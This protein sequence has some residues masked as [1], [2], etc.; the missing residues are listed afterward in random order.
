MAEDLGVSVQSAFCSPTVRR[1]RSLPCE[2]SRHQFEC[3]PLHGCARDLADALGRDLRR[4]RSPSGV[5]HV[6]HHVCLSL[7]RPSSEAHWS[8][9][10]CSYIATCLGLAFTQTYWLLMLLRCLQAAGSASVVALGAGAIGDLAP[11]KERGGYM[12]IYSLGA[13]LGPCI[14]PL[15]GGLLADR[16]DWHAIFFF[17]AAFSAVVFCVMLLALPEV[18][19]ALAAERALGLTLTSCH[20]DF[21]IDGRERLD[22]AYAPRE[23]FLG[24]GLPGTT[25]ANLPSTG[26]NA[27]ASPA[28][29][30]QPFRLARHA[31]GARRLPPPHL[32]R[33]RL[34]ALLREHYLVLAV[35]QSQVWPLR[36]RARTVLSCKRWRHDLR[37]GLQRSSAQP[38]L[39]RR[40]SEA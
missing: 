2:F 8:L 1:N 10:R 37:V 40:C 7:P 14:G 18:R 26:S 19:P 23:S 12:G 9:S 34:L 4:D 15:A 29:F 28:S 36:K 16:W 38:R 3:H 6:L 31:Q 17:L 24:L 33:H 5:P 13:M 32:Q 22:P 20:A 35:G 30:H 39:P 27:S 11:P 21:A 25:A